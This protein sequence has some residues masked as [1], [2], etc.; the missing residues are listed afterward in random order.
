[1][2]PSAVRPDAHFPPSRQLFSKTDT[3]NFFDFDRCHA[4]ARPAHPPPTIAT[5]TGRF[6]GGGAVETAP[7]CAAARAGEGLRGADDRFWPRRAGPSLEP[8]ADIDG[9]RVDDRADMVVDASG[10]RQRRPVEEGARQRD[11][12]V[13][14]EHVIE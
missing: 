5:R 6:A 1:M 14:E 7:V 13:V 12:R 3:S 9:N 11:P 4:A 2:R 10:G 8:E